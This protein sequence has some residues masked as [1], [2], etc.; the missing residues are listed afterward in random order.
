MVKSSEETV[1]GGGERHNVVAKCW[2]DYSLLVFKKRG[3]DAPHF[4]ETRVIAT[5]KKKK[6]KRERRREEFKV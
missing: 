1:G 3:G 5:E 4:R 6:K 2:P